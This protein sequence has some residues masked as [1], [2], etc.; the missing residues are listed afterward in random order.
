RMTDTLSQELASL[1][2]VAD[3]GLVELHDGCVQVTAAGWF[4]VRAIAMTFDHYLQTA[5]ERHRFS[6]VV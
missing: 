5:R 4:L 6:R 3:A 1:R 2:K